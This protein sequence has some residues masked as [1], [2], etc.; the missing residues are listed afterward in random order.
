MATQD[1]LQSIM[2]GFDGTMAMIAKTAGIYGG[3][4]GE[5]FAA[6]F[7]VMNG[8]ITG[9]VSFEGSAQVRADLEKAVVGVGAGYLADVLAAAGIRMA[10]AA[11]IGGTAA[12]VSPVLIVGAGAAALVAGLNGDNIYNQYTVVQKAFLK[13]MIDHN[14]DTKL[15]ASINDLY[16]SAKNWS[17]PRA[18][19]L[20]LDL[21]RDGIETIGIG[22]AANVL[23]DHDGDGVKTATGWVKADDGMLVLDR[24]GN[25]TIDNGGELFGDQTLVGGVKAAN[26]FA[27]L[28]AEDTNKN[29]KFDAGDANFTKVRIW[30]DKNSDGVSQTDELRTLSELGTPQRGLFCYA[31]HLLTSTASNNQ[32]FK[33]K[34]RVA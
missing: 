31:I 8:T 15:S 4:P 24:N 18:D 32:N 16:T 21:D 25:G 22:S 20:V 27:A 17:P 26:G 1:N 6:S 13:W 2:T 12:A 7:G 29:G 19:P 30:Q 33:N 28:S 3:A 11:A 5:V 9:V 10:L 14:Y 34:R 23:F